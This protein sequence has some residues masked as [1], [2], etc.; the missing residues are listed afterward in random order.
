MLEWI[1]IFDYFIYHCLL[2][3]LGAYI[4]WSQA[5]NIIWLF[6][7]L[8]VIVTVIFIIFSNIIFC[9]DKWSLCG[10]LVSN[11]KILRA[12]VG[13]LIEVTINLI[14]LWKDLV[15]TRIDDLCVYSDIPTWVCQDNTKT[16]MHTG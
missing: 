13:Y 16:C 10:D 14:L 3:L 2:G 5:T 15:N 9:K 6:Y 7:D 1:V 4:W 11:E 8:W 12:T